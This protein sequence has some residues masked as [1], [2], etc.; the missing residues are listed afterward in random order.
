M[1]SKLHLYSLIE[2]R[3]AR[4]PNSTAFIIDGQSVS[5]GQFDEICRCLTTWLV[6]QGIG[7]GDVVAVWLVNRIEWLALLFSVARLGA[8]IASIN[9]RYRRDEVQD[10]LQRSGAGM[11]I[12][13][14]VFR[15]IN[16]TEVFSSIESSALP[17]LEK[18]ALVDCDSVPTTLAGK[19]VIPLTNNQ[20]PDSS[21]SHT[22]PETTL[23]FFTTS[24][25][26]SEPKLVRQSQRSHTIHAHD[27]ATAHGLERSGT[28]LLASL[29]LCGTF[30]LNSVLAAFAAA[31]PV[32]LQQ[33]FDPQEALGLMETYSVTH[34]YGSD[35]MVRRLIDYSEDN[36]PFAHLRVFGFGA[37][38]SNLDDYALGAWE[39]GIPLYGMYGSSEVLS[40]FSIQR[41]YH[42][43][44]ERIQ[45]GGIPS[46]RNSKVRIRDT[47]SGQLL[48]MLETGEI[49][50]YSPTLF[51]DYLNNPGATDEAVTQDG[52]F[53]T[54]DLGYS[55]DDGS[56]VFQS[57]MGDTIR[58]SGFLVNPAEIEAV[59]KKQ[60]GVHDA[61]VVAIDIKGSPRPVALVMPS[62]EQPE[63]QNLIKACSDT[64]APFKVPARVWFVDSFPVSFSANGTKVQRNKLRKRAIVL[65]RNEGL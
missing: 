8:S 19:P 14:S 64:M 7:R 10:I 53:R 35:E 31:A 57:R 61:C 34:I 3:L 52:W 55:R 24:G 50:I 13:Q 54:N 2:E 28:V 27:V 4:D 1:C 37:F 29:P 16:F 48:P 32:V 38:G 5:V 59:L 20:Q 41:H 60:D 47:V 33:T 36:K 11:L 58:L 17:K 63:V 39:K 56:F 51:N 25:T 6:Q 43:V 42:K 15:R 22:E 46:I 18:V 30:G 45:G 49:E 21:H 9:T 23:I 12:M 40:L 44:E 65:L 26:T 62:S